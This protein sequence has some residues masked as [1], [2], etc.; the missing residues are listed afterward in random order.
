[1]IKYFPIFINSDNIRCL[2]VGGG[3]IAERKIMTLLAYGVKIIVV[4]PIVTNSIKKNSLKN[5]IE[6]KERKFRRTD[7]KNIKVLI[8]AT[9]DIKLNEKISKEAEKY[10]ILVNAIT[11][12]EKGN[13]IFPSVVDR[14][15]LKIAVSTSGLCPALS[16]KIR[17][18]L[19]KQF[20]RNYEEYLNFISKIRLIAL[21]KNKKE[22]KRIIQDLTQENILNLIEKKNSNLWKMQV[23]NIISRYKL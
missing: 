16:L 12:G 9:S 20:C 15:A 7:L 4:S 19:D 2:V 3:K 13:F 22:Y 11:D 14:G 8:L 1:M 10:N 5:K 21:S 18:R 17:E 6:L 23:N